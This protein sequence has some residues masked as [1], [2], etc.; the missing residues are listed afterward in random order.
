M[1]NENTQG[2]LQAQSHGVIDKRKALKVNKN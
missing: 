2:G 1:Q